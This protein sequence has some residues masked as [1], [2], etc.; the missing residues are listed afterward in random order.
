MLFL[1]LWLFLSETVSALPLQCGANNSL[2]S[3][4]SFETECVVSSELITYSND[5]SEDG[6]LDGP[7]PHFGI[8]ETTTKDSSYRVHKFDD[9]STVSTRRFASENDLFKSEFWKKLQK[10]KDPATAMTTAIYI[11]DTGA[12]LYFGPSEYRDDLEKRNPWRK[13]K[14]REVEMLEVQF[15]DKKKAHVTDIPVSWCVSSKLSS[16][17]ASYTQSYK[18]TKAITVSI[19]IHTSVNVYTAGAG[20]SA[21]NDDLSISLSNTGSITCN[22]APGKKVQVFGSFAYAFF[23]FAKKRSVIFSKSRVSNGPWAKVVHG[24]PRL[25]SFGA[26]FFDL[27]SGPPNYFCVDDPNKLSCD[28]GSIVNNKFSDPAEGLLHVD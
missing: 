13:P 7:L 24:N 11:E 17:G 1:T 16:S 8:N 18:W 26:I 10:G 25:K 5:A 14:S 3:L 9:G 6:D 22:A 23:P 19:D 21:G 27:S 15:G 20:V 2:S 4:V 12:T 28:E